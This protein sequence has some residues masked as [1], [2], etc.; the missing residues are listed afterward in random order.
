MENAQ[1]K[2]RKRNLKWGTFTKY[3]IE[4]GYRIK[5]KEEKQVSFSPPF[6]PFVFFRV[7]RGLCMKEKGGTKPENKWKGI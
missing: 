6:F 3:R 7:G 4:Q 1:N 2:Q 5:W